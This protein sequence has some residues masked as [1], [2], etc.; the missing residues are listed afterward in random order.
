MMTMIVEAKAGDGG[1][2]AALAH[3][4]WPHDNEEDLRILYE[5]LLSATENGAVFLAFDDKR[6]VGFAQCQLRRDYVEGA[7]SSPVGYLEG[8]WVEPAFRGQGVAGRLLQKCQEWAKEKGCAEFASDCEIHNSESLSFHLQ[9]GF[10]EA[11]RII[12]LIKRSFFYFF[13]PPHGIF[14]QQNAMGL[15]GNETSLCGIPPYVF[16]VFLCVGAFFP[17]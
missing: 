8:I 4:L 15:S 2:V 10:R 1:L 9:N 11:N 7:E 3:R 16:S 14:P 5:R 6:A 12:C 13:L 17:L